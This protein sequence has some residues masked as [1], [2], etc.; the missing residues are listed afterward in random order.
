MLR[1]KR[2]SDSVG[3]CGGPGPEGLLR[4]KEEEFSVWDPRL[5]MGYETLLP[6][7]PQALIPWTRNPEL[8]GRPFTVSDKGV[9]DRNQLY[10]TTSALDFRAYS[11]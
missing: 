7:P 2:D 10:L 9:L 11:K 5:Q 1:V 6:D 3:G 4:P 8:A